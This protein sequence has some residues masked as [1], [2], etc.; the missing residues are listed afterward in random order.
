MRGLVSCFVSAPMTPEDCDART[1][2]AERMAEVVSYGRDREA[3]LA[4]AT[5]WREKAEKLRK[6]AQS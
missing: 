3:L 4:Q 2:R 5:E 6:N 1:A